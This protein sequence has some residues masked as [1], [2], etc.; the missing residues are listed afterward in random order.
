[1]IIRISVENCFIPKENII[2]TTAM[3]MLRPKQNTAYSHGQLV[4]LDKGFCNQRVGFGAF[5][6]ML[7]AFLPLSGKYIIPKFNK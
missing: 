1:M 3:S 5:V 2:P 7:L 4:V 6:R